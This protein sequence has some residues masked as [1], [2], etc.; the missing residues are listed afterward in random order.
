MPAACCPGPPFGA[1]R[2]A[3]GSPPTG[4]GNPFQRG[5]LTLN[6]ERSITCEAEVFAWNLPSTYQTTRCACAANAPQR[7]RV[8]R[9][10][11]G[12]MSVKGCPTARVVNGRPGWPTMGSGDGR[13]RHHHD[14]G[15]MA[16]AATPTETA[17]IIPIDAAEPAVADH[18]RQLDVA[19]S[20]GVPAHV[21]V[22][23][24]FVHPSAVDADVISRLASALNSVPAFDCTFARCDGFGEEVLWLAPE[25]DGPLRELTSAVRA[26]VPRI[27]RPT[28]GSS[29]T[30]CHT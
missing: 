1:Y 3:P 5:E 23:Y 11:L 30:L 9:R 29:T 2:P 17:V 12:G 21:S 16:N 8:V 10:T 26:R 14:R 22:L 18:R 7:D 28:P 25:P 13:R 20:W 19:A 15:K 4:W 6:S 27:T 24:P